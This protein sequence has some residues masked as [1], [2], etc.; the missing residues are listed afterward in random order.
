MKNAKTILFAGL[1]AAMV[2]PFS[3]MQFAEA[4]KV[5]NKMIQVALLVDEIETLINEL[6]ESEN[7]SPKQQ[8]KLQVQIDEKMKKFIGF[9]TKTDG[10]VD[11]ELL[12]EASQTTQDIG[13]YSTEF[14]TTPSCNHV[15]TF[16]NP[17]VG[18]DYET[19]EFS[20][21]SPTNPLIVSTCSSGLCVDNIAH[22]LYAPFTYT[23]TPVDLYFD[24]KYTY[25][26]DLVTGQSTNWLLLTGNDSTNYWWNTPVN[27]SSISWSI[28][29][30]ESGSNSK[31]IWV[32]ASF[33]LGFNAN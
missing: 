19:S 22:A 5:D 30:Y 20:F 12:V 32:P 27:H 21:T 1:I 18:A 17:C 10:Q 15:G 24:K 29:Y 6:D 11:F 4:D 23:H 26:Y 31:V 28:N 14:F 25:G 13:D 7:N 8:A 33:T 3:G 9:T 16:E 2:L